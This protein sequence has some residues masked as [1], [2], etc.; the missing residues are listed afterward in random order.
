MTTEIFARVVFQSPLPALEREF[1]YLVPSEL[2]SSIQIG[3][4]VKVRFAGQRKEG[5]V[6][7]LSSEAEFKGK[8]NSIIELVSTVPVLQGHVYQTLKAV[9][10]R[11]A[12]SV[13]EL[14][15]NAVPKRSVRVEKAFLFSDSAD[16]VPALDI[17]RAEL[18]RPAY[19]LETGQPGFVSR[20]VELATSY[21]QKGRSVILCVPDFRD[22]QCVSKLLESAVGTDS[23][24]V[25]D[26]SDVG[27][28]R[29][30]AFLTQLQPNPKV[31][32]GTRSAI[33]SPVHGTA[34]IIVW[35]DGDQSHQ[36]QQSPYL[37]TREIALI[38]QSLFHGP[39]HFLSHAR[40]TDLQRLVQ[41]GYL[42]EE[43]YDSWRPKVSISDGRG[44]DATAFKLIKQG[45]ESGPVLFQV[46]APG[47]ARSLYCLACNVR[48]TCNK[49]HGPLWL[50]A[51]GQIVCRWCGQ[52]N[53]DFRCLDCGGE[54]LSQGAAGATRWVEQLGKSFPGIAIREV[55]VDSGPTSVSAKP[56]IIVSTPGI[57]PNAKNG[58]SAVV[59][60][61]CMAQ[62]SRDSLRAPEDALRAW[63]NALAF[64]ATTGSA[65]AV[66]VSKEVS[67]ALSLGEVIDTAKEILAEREELGFPPAK[68]MLSAVGSRELVTK[69]GEF[70]SDI[71]GVQVLGVASAQSS[72][73]E[74]DFRMIASF[75]Y[76]SGN[77]VAIAAKEF[78]ASVSSKE[79]RTNAKTGRSIR[80]VTIKFDDPRVL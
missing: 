10:A 53:L 19:N 54:K 15:D 18:V 76:G 42:S 9:A 47:T 70:L 63:L 28:K 75:T 38:R 61:D 72:T 26:S 77:Q 73:N 78:I 16:E 68:R 35:D 62:L 74:P 21:L 41:I 57:E 29:Y 8:L 6:V 13:G 64:M 69:F 5:F 55:T 17:R 71:H 79:L 58:Y 7:G 43:S 12:C 52:F 31:V 23:V 1:E 11:Q 33:Y 37:N 80:P 2:V 56:Q 25:M 65:V 44:L 36:D 32:L 66:G 22:I 24:V 3:C 60:V 67:K 45:L 14:L 51:A 50:N 39:L 34:A 4:R 40:S 46:A 20:L 27:S 30:E 49:C 48:S 59:F